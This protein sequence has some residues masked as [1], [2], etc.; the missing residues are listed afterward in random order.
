MTC[1]GNMHDEEREVVLSIVQW[2]ACCTHI[3]HMSM[4]THPRRLYTHLYNGGPGGMR[5]NRPE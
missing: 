1:T 3:A 5:D 4:Y 2:Y